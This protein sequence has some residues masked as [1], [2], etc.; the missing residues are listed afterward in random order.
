SGGGGGNDPGQGGGGSGVMDQIYFVS[1]SNSE[2]AKLASENNDPSFYLR[3]GQEITKPDSVFIGKKIVRIEFFIAEEDKPRGGT[4]DGVHVRIRKGIDDSIVTT[5]G[6]IDEDDLHDDGNTYFVED[7]S[8][9]YA[10]Q[11]GDKILFE[12]DG[13][14]DSDYV[15]LFMKSNQPNTGSKVVVQDNTQDPGE[16]RNLNRDVSMRIWAVT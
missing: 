15:K 14:S 13:G 5:L 8:N 1:S 12:Y 4:G 3:F 2:T 16:Y 9:S 11:V 7:M 6:T 10:M